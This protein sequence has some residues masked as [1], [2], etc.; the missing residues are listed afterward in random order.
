[1]TKDEQIF[2]QED[3]TA[4]YC[5]DAY[6][7]KIIKK[8]VDIGYVMDPHTATCFKADEKLKTKKLKNVICSTAE[9]TKFAPTMLNAINEDDKKYSDLEALES[10]SKKLNI[11]ITPSVSALFGKKV[12]H[13]KIVA[14]ESI[15]KE[16]LK[17]INA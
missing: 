3:F 11:E 6:G 13:D 7:Q 2:L 16:I 12:L 17:F 9:W 15:E 5:D 8:Y 1:L 10:I 14:K 4:V